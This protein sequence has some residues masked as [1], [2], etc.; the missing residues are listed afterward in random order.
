MKAPTTPRPIASTGETVRSLARPVCRH[1]AGVA[2]SPHGEH[3]GRYLTAYARRRLT[4]AD[5]IAAISGLG[6]ISARQLVPERAA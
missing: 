4:K 2:C 6:V 3:V 1:R 5:L